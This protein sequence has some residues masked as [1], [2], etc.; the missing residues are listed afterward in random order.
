VVYLP[1]KEE[2]DGLGA[3]HVN[4]LSRA[5]EQVLGLSAHTPNA[6]PL[7]QVEVIWTDYFGDTDLYTCV[8]RYY[9]G[10]EWVTDDLE[11]IAYPFDPSADENVSYSV[12]DK[13]AAYFDDQRSAYIPIKSGG[14]T[15]ASAS[16]SHCGCEVVT[17]PD[18]EINGKKATYTVA[19][20]LGRIVE[21]QEC[22]ILVLKG[23]TYTLNNT[24]TRSVPTEIWAYTVA[25]SDFDVFNYAGNAATTDDPI[26]GTITWN[27][28]LDPKAKVIIDVAAVI[29][30]P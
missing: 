9:D 8:P 1:K 27:P 13:V 25:A 14:G 2:G 6:N 19:I 17:N 24:G 12:G 23:A 5:A 16:V 21:F 18:I 11:L 28:F 10:D 29:S 7:R 15:G 30:S 3:E 26:E 20:P 22:G 4:T